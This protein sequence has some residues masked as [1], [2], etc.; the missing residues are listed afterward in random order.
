MNKPAATTIM[1]ISPRYDSSKPAC[2]ISASIAMSAK[3]TRKSGNSLPKSAI[4]GLPPAGCGGRT[5]CRRGNTAERSE[6]GL[7]TN[8]GRSNSA[9]HAGERHRYRA[10]APGLGPAHA[11]DQADVQHGVPRGR[12]NPAGPVLCL[13][14]TIRDHK[15]GARQGRDLVRYSGEW[16]VIE[17]LERAPDDFIG[18]GCAGTRR[19]YTKTTS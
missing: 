3:N 16:E 4:S 19:G 5:P 2:R 17:V 9:R 6:E 8:F 18:A 12:H 1:P 10:G 7:P 15:V 14:E 13:G 11:F